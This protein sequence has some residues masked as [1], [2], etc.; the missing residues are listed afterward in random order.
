MSRHTG[1]IAGRVTKQQAAEN[2][3]ARE[4]LN[5]ALG[6]ASP[7]TTATQVANAAKGAIA[8]PA[9]T[10]PSTPAA[11]LAAFE[12]K[13]PGKLAEIA[14]EMDAERQ[15]VIKRYQQLYDSVADRH[16]LLRDTPSVL[17]ADIDKAKV[18]L[19]TANPTEKIALLAKI[20]S[21][22]KALLPAQLKALT[23]EQTKLIRILKDIG[24]EPTPNPAQP[25][26]NEAVTTACKT[27]QEAQ[28]ARSPA[29]FNHSQMNR[30]ADVKR[31]VNYD[32][33]VKALEEVAA[34]YPNDPTLGKAVAEFNADVEALNKA[35][36][37]VQAITDKMVNLDAVNAYSADLAKA[38]AEADKISA[39]ISSQLDTKVGGSRSMLQRSLEQACH[40]SGDA[41][42]KKAYAKHLHNMSLAL[43]EQDDVLRQLMVR[44]GQKPHD[45]NTRGKI[46]ELGNSGN[47]KPS[48]PN[49]RSSE[50][51][52]KTWDPVEKKYEEVAIRVGGS[53][54]PKAERINLTFEQVQEA[55]RRWNKAHP[56]NQMPPPG[57]DWFGNGWS[58]KAG[59]NAADFIAGPMTDVHNEVHH[60]KQPQAAVVQGPAQQPAAAVVQGPPA[61]PAVAAGG[62]PISA[63][64]V[65]VAPPTATTPKPGSGGGP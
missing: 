50:M 49:S 20:A 12:T 3:K 59:K 55:V 41:A 44:T 22:E 15:A 31:N 65:P 11:A 13:A 45:E 14:A 39:S 1:Q 58:L 61:A 24:P 43:R 53:T 8:P 7:D 10:V 48:D 37:K 19:A 51:T 64:G 23:D 36:A 30:V 25:P 35:T 63:A 47:I 56:D 57:K 60:P 42:D 18:D 29:P 28:A 52:Y 40:D 62:P 5:A 21:L 9:A 34:K 17:Q 46:P 33:A 2:N 32:A 6:L 54:D 16:K 27:A 26:A 4:L 38:A